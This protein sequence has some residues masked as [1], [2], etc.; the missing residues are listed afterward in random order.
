M[1][2]IRSGKTKDIFLLSNGNILLKFKDTVTGQPTGESDPGGNVVIGSVEGVGGYALRMT[3]HYFELLNK[4]GVPN[5]FVSADIGKN[6]MEVK[7]VQV[8]GKGLE[9]VCR[10]VAAGSFVRRYGD[11]CREG[12][13]LP[14]VFEI[15]LKDDERD[16]PPATK[17]TLTALKLMTGEQYDIIERDTV[18]IARIIRDDMKKKRLDLYDIK[19]EF[20][21]YNGTPILIDEISG[22]NMRVYKNGKKLDYLSLSKLILESK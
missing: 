1:Q 9:C 4:L 15:T 17:Q 14:D 19:F 8:F 6:E 2:F 11:Y 22:G 16:D 7:N 5:H 21:I 3:K 20:G 18:K 13:I 12:E 10:F